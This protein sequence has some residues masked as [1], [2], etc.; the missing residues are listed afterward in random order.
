MFLVLGLLLTSLPS[1]ALVAHAADDRGTEAALKY[2][3]FGSIS[4]AILAFGVTFWFGATG[5]TSLAQLSHLSGRPW[6]AALGL[7]AVFVGLGYKAALV[8]FHFW[9][10][11]AYDGAP[12]AVAAYLSV[13]PKT[14]AIFAVTQV[15]RLFP[16]DGPD[17]RP[18][19]S[20]LAAISMTWGNFAALRQESMP[21]LLA[22]S[23][24]A[25]AGYFLLGVVAT[26]HSPMAAQSLIVFAAA[27]ASMNLGAFAVVA[28]A[29]LDLAA[30][31]GLARSAPWTAAAMVCFLLSLVG[32]PP[33]AGFAG[34]FLLFGAALDAGF[35]WL[36]GIA[37]ANSVLSLAVYL[38]VVARMYSVLARPGKS[39][40]P[41]ATAAVMGAALSI[42]LLLGVAAQLLLDH[43]ET[44]AVRATTANVAAPPP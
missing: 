13:V 33:L 21:R 32:V 4:G 36:A 39:R 30:F 22:Y 24:I 23:S 7:A 41:G 18:A 11:D 12:I 43:G 19:V 37:I 20:L 17:W 6:A 40:R 2:F 42:T 31:A 8:P 27:Y 15:L 14:G 10:P 29:G 35:A 3:V 9:A 44:D 16:P 28:S 5:S 34:K 26:G 38:R 25:Q 1:F